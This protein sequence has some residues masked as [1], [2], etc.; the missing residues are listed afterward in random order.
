MSN[1]DAINSLLCQTLKAL[2]VGFQQSNV[3]DSHS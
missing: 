2:I 3:W 1:K